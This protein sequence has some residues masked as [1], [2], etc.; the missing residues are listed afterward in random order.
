[1]RTAYDHKAL[2]IAITGLFTVLGVLYALIATPIYRA[3]AMI[4]IEPKAAITGIPEISPPGLGFP[5]GHRNFLLKSRAVLGKAV[6]ELKL[7]IVA[8]PRQFPLIGGYGPSA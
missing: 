3:T 8:K 1:M 4:Q 5:G 6:E 7:Y 2:I